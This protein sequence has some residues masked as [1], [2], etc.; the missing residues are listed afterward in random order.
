MISFSR[1]DPI[2][3][4][5]VYSRENIRARTVVV[6]VAAQVW[7]LLILVGTLLAAAGAWFLKS[8]DSVPAEMMWWFF[9]TAAFGLVGSFALHESAH[10]MVLKRI[11]TVTHLAIVRMLWRI[12]VVPFGSLTARQVV[13][14]AI[15]G[16]ISCVAVGAALWTSDLDPSLA[17]WFLAHG[18]LLLPLFGDGRSLC[19]GLR[20]R[21]AI[22]DG[23]QAVFAGAR[24]QTH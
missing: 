21:G 15:A 14:V 1:R 7:P 19:R 4:V 20:G 2:S 9:K 6:A 18:I 17:W 11:D 12:S 5:R 13:T 16:P 23:S 3:D 24:R 22:A 8:G 10:M